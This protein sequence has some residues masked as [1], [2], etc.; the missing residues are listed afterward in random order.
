MIAQAQ[1]AYENESYTPLLELYGA[2]YFKT[3]T[4]FYPNLQDAPLNPAFTTAAQKEVTVPNRTV[5]A[6]LY[7]AGILRPGMTVRN[8]E[9][10]KL[11]PIGG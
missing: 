9:T 11:I 10:G 7:A 4:E 6:Q 1:E 2:E 3:V 5:A 8:L